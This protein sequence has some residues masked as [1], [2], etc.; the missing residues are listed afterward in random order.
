MDMYAVISGEYDDRTVE[1]LVAD[2]DLADEI[3]EWA[4]TEH[5]FA[6]GEYGAFRVDAATIPVVGSLEEA[7]AQI[8]TWPFP[9]KPSTLTDPPITVALSNI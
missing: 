4:N 7:Q 9:A 2:A 8:G 1:V 5:G 3:A 6:P